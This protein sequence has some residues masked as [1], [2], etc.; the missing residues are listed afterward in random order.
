MILLTLL[1]GGG[2]LVLLAWY[3][4]AGPPLPVD[5]ARTDGERLG[6]DALLCL[7]FFAQ[8]SGMIRRGVKQRIARWAPSGYIPALYSIASAIALL[9]LVL[10]WQ[11]TGDILYRLHGPARW[12][13]VLIAAGAI[14]GYVWGIR[15][16]RGFDPFGTVP[17]RAMR[18]G[19]PV[20]SPPF[21]ARGPYR[22]VR[23]PLYLFMIV[24]FWAAP[25]LST[26]RLLFNV[27]WTAWVFAGTMLEERDLV[28]EF[29][30]T[31]RSYQRS[32]PMLIPSLR[33]RL[34]RPEAGD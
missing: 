6:I 12:A 16:L 7:L 13:M 23:H 32:V 31:Y 19:A 15:G 3:L 21:V 1:L 20:P 34:A 24:L 11:P 30:Q 28:R 26:D 9:P 5:I 18:R 4:G 10:L 8:H 2:S 25:R 14:A 27:L 22:H 33:R 29:G 17:L